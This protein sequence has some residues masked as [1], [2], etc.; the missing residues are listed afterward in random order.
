MPITPIKAPDGSIIKVQHPDGATKKEIGQAAEIIY[1][2]RLA[3]TADR[4]RRRDEIA[5]SD[6]SEFDPTS[7]AFQEKFGAASGGFLEN[8][9]AGSGKAFA[10]IGRGAN[11]LA[12]EAADLIPGVDLSERVARLRSES[13]DA[14]ERDAEL[15]RS[16]GGL[17]GN[18]GT[19]IGLALT[20]GGLARGGAGAASTA[21]RAFSNPNTLRAAAGSG[22]VQG[23]LQP[24]A[25]DELRA[26]NT[27]AGALFG[28]GGRLLTKP[29]ASNASDAAKRAI[30]RLESAGVPLDVAERTQSRAAA[31]LAAQLDDSIISGGSRESFKQKQLRGFTKAVLRTIGADADEASERVMLE[32]KNR[33]G[34]VFDDFAQQKSIAADRSFLQSMGD[35]YDSAQ[36]TLTKPEFRL[37]ERNWKD[38]MSSIDNGSINGSRF[39][40]HRSTLS[41][42]SRRPDVGSHASAMED[43]LLNALERSHSAADRQAISAAR[44]QWRN[45]RTLQGAVGKGEERFISPLRLSNALSTKRNQALSVFGQGN[46][47]SKELSDLARAGREILGDFANSGTPVRQQIPTAG[48]LGGLGATAGLPG[49]LGGAAAI[50]GASAAINSQGLLGNLLA[51]GLP[52]AIAAPLKQSMIAQGLLTQENLLEQ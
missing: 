43:S 5:Q 9:L 21:A 18:I 19:N 42:L 23:A 13:T 35:V 11:Q 49:V 17:T 26:F 47:I 46:D 45:L 41:N 52:P 30:K 38:I 34:G 3:A 28:V 15:M 31:T 16:A 44:A 10:D 24:V 7:K 48:V 25:E 20:P 32:S 50:R 1:N 12:T 8:L 36:N 14:R 2:K 39:I 22:A 51:N 40:R 4:E 6:P 37:F 27:G 29:F 33:I